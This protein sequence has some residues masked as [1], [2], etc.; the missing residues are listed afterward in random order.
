ML[1]YALVLPAMQITHEGYH[2]VERPESKT[3]A[4]SFSFGNHFQ[5]LS[6]VSNKGYST[7]IESLAEAVASVELRLIDHR[8][9]TQA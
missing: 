7:P 2:R 6:F 3:T 1:N 5:I 8:S 4:Y 9:T